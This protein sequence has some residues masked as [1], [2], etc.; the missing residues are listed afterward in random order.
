M[1]RINM[2]YNP[3][4]MGDNVISGS[5]NACCVAQSQRWNEAIIHVIVTSMAMV[6]EIKYRYFI[7]G[8]MLVL[9]LVFGVDDLLD[10][11]FFNS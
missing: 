6:E 10:L 5:E 8:L 7:I 1:V 4:E 3:P 9:F 11:D 2:K